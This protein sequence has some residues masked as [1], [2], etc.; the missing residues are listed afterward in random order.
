M[1]IESLYT[2][3]YSLRVAVAALV[4]W[5]SAACATEKTTPIDEL[6]SRVTEK[7][8]KKRIFAEFVLPL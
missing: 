2:I 4:C 3:G 8:A 7:F 5:V 1:R 6:A